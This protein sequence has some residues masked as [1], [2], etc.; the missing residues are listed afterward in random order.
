MSVPPI[1]A[2]DV[3]HLG[4]P[5]QDF[6]KSELLCRLAIYSYFERDKLETILH[7]QPWQGCEIWDIEQNQGF[8]VWAENC[9]V[10]SYRG[11][12]SP[13]DWSQNAKALWPKRHVLGGRIHRGFFEVARQAKETVKRSLRAIDGQHRHLWIT[14]HSLG[15]AVATEL[16]GDLMSEALQGFPTW[17]VATFGSPRLGNRSFERTYESNIGAG[18]CL[19]HWAYVNDGDPVPHLPKNFQGYRHCGQL[20]WFNDQGKL[21]DV[22]E[23]EVGLENAPSPNESDSGKRWHRL[24]DGIPDFQNEDEYENFLNTLG[25][26]IGMATDGIIVN[27]ATGELQLEVPEGELQGALGNLIAKHH[28]ITLYLERLRALI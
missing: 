25:A 24:E 21:V 23:N 14:G 18:A 10:V 15:G 13:G 7:G 5:E 6:R 2:D 22:K 26:Q 17:E 8:I 4:Q 12:D 28:K 1:S 16:S 3:A 19:S 20:R 9:A 27:P 11:T